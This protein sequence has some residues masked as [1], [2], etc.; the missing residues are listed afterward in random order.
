MRVL[1]AAGI[2]VVLAACGPSAAPVDDALAR[3]LEL[4]GTTSAFELAPAADGM[5]VMSALEQG[6]K[7]P[8]AAPAPVPERKRVAQAPRK[9]VRRQAPAPRPA[10]QEVAELP[11]PAPE[12]V[13]EQPAPAPRPAASAPASQSAPLGSGPAPAGG[14]RNVNDVIRNSRVPITP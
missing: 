1:A 13:I 12:P 2:T 7:A 11:A 8:A 3:D 14:W 10:R 4:V 5:Q 9:A 6:A